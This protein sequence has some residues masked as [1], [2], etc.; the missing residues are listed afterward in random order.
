MD[1]VFSVTENPFLQS[2]WCW[3]HP[4]NPYPSQNIHTFTLPSCQLPLYIPTHTL[5]HVLSLKHT[6]SYIL[7]HRNRTYESFPSSGNTHSTSLSNLFRAVYQAPGK[8]VK[9]LPMTFIQENQWPNCQAHGE[10]PTE[11]QRKQS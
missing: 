5:A 2:A 4:L 10:T 6:L 1:P 9:V 7:S 8:P 11:R 3:Y